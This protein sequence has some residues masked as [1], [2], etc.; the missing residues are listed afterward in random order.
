M[1]TKT[2]I[3]RNE[4]VSF[5][6]LGIENIE[7]KIDTGAYSTAI[8]THKIWVEEIDEK[9][10]LFFELFDP[11]HENYRDLIIKTTNFF[12]K[13]VRSSNGRIEKRFIIRTPMTLGGKKRQTH[14]S[15]TNREKMKYPILV[16]RKFLSKGFLVDVSLSNLT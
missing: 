13:K 7:A 10:T 11:V 5:P 2:I 4:K 12:R 14:L 15:L 16:G 6:E 1:R 8:H 3:G 9:E